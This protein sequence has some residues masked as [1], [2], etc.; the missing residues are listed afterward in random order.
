MSVVVRKPGFRIGSS[1]GVCF[2]PDGKRLAT[3][4][5]RVVLWDVDERARIRWVH[6]SRP[7]AIDFSPDGS[8]LAV[9]STAGEIVLLD[10]VS[11][12]VV[13]EPAHKRWGEG[14]DV[15]FSPCGRY[16]VDGTWS[17]DLVGRDA[18]SGEVVWQDHVANTAILTSSP[19]P[20][21]SGG[22]STA[23]GR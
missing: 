3:F 17:G 2:S 6:R 11:L 18:S 8:H 16:L 4:G 5:R 21:V 13:A 1:Y 9:K 10:A 7:D 15:M 20:T 14:S 23:P 12:Q 19:H 22:S